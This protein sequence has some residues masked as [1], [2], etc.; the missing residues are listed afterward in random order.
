MKKKKKKDNATA[1]VKVY[2]SKAQMK[3]ERKKMRK[4]LLKAAQR[5]DNLKAASDEHVRT[6]S[7]IMSLYYPLVVIVDKL[8]L[9]F[10]LKYL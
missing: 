2:A 5:E 10:S 1:A 8:S 9:C 4:K 3:A 7:Y 6:Y